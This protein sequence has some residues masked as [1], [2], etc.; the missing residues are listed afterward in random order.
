MEA[1]DRGCQPRHDGAS[2]RLPCH[3]VYSQDRSDQGACPP[4]GGLWFLAFGAVS[5]ADDLSLAQRLSEC[6][7]KSAWLA[8]HR[9]WCG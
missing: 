8:S 2:R 5:L 7:L 1:F 4:H 3:L 9:V 6:Q